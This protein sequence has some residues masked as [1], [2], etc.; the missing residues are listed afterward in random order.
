MH[1][2]LDDTLREDYDHMLNKTA[3][4]NLNIIRKWCYSMMKNVEFYKSNLAIRRKM[5]II[6]FD[7]AKYL[8]YV[9]FL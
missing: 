3:T 5:F 4:A 9:M 8:D 7:P 2:Q 6:S 1:W